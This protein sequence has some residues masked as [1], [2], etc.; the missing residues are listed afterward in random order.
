MNVPVV[1]L[2]ECI[3]C[4]VCREAC[5]QVFKMNDVGFIEVMELDGYPEVEVNEAIACC[6]SGCIHW[7]S[8]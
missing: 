8:S 6:P 1:E 7:E 4:E 5:S 2:S 3:K